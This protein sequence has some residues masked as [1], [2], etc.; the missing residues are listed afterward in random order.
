[1]LVSNQLSIA[2]STNQSPLWLWP[3]VWGALLLMSVVGITYAEPLFRLI[4]P[5]ARQVV[6]AH[7]EFYVL[8][9]RH[10]LVVGL[11]AVVSIAVGVLMGVAVTRQHGREFL[12]LVGQLA[13]LGQT[14]APVAVLA[15]AVPVMGFGTLPIIVASIL[16]GLITILRS[17]LTGLQGV[18]ANIKLA[19]H[20][21]GLTS[22]Q[23]LRYVELPLAAPVILAGIRA[24]VTLNVATA[25]LGAVVG[26]SNLGAPI[27][28]GIAGGNMA[29]IVQGTLTVALLALTLNSLFTMLHRHLYARLS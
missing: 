16:I 1:M 5:N 15:L 14:L 27:I 21:M 23:T 3:L 2:H 6:Y 7:A 29:Y 22:L 12:P 11:A 9:G 8:L 10:L 19:A 18:D 4:E 13:S 20:A 17:T 25:A 26:A 28:A 24:S